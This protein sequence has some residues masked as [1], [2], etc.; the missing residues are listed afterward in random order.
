M[1]SVE[2]RVDVTG[3][4]HAFIILTGPDGIDRGYGP[5]PYRE[6][7][8]QA[9]GHIYDDTNHPYDRTTGKIQISNEQYSRLTDYVNKSIANPPPYDL[10][11]GSQC[12]TWA[13][14]ALT[15]AGIPA[16]ASP[17]LVPDNMFRDLFETIAWNPYTQWINLLARDSFSNA[18][19]WQPRRDPLTLDLD[20]D[21]LETVA[22]S[23]S[24]PI[25]FD[26]DGD[27]LKTSTG[28]VSA[29]DGFLVLDRNGNGL[30]DNGAELFGDATALYTGGLAVDGFA[31][32]AQED[33]NDDGK[34]DAEDGRWRQ[35]M[36]WRDL[37]QDGISQTGELVT[38]DQAGIAS[39]GVA[40]T[41]NS[42]TLANGN[43]I[44]DLGSFV[45]TGGTSGVGQMADINLAED[46]FY[47]QFGDKVAL[48][49]GVAALPELRGSGAVRDLRESASL[50]PDLQA[51]LTQFAQATTGPQQRALLGQLLEAWA[52]TSGLAGTLAERAGGQYAVSFQAIGNETRSG[53]ASADWSGTVDAWERKLHV[54]EAFNGRYFFRLPNEA[55]AGNLAA[56]G[57]TL[58]AATG[59]GSDNGVLQINVA[60]SQ[61]QADLLDQSY[62]ALFQSIYLSLAMQTRLRPVLDE[63]GLVF[64]EAGV[65]LDF[66]AVEQH[67]HE[68][69]KADVVAGLADLIDFNQGVKG[70][71]AT[72]GWQGAAMLAQYMATLPLTAELLAMFAQAGV[73]LVGQDGLYV[74]GSVNDEIMLLDAAGA[75]AYGNGGDDVLVGRAG[76]DRL[77]GD[78]GNDALDGGAGSDTLE[79][80]TGEDMLRGGAGA[81][82]LSGNEGNDRLDGGAGD[83]MLWGGTGD[84]TYLFARGDGVDRISDHDTTAGNMDVVQ[85]T[86]VTSAEVKS[87]ERHGHDLVLRYGDADALTLNFH[88]DYSNPAYK[89]EQIRFSD[90]VRWDEAAIKARVITYGS[91]AGD[92]LSGYADG[93]NQL[94]GLGGND[95]LDGGS[96]N[97]VIDGGGGN[98]TLYGN[99]GDDLL[100][101]GAGDD[102]I[103]GGDGADTIRFGKGYGS[104][105]F[106]SVNSAAFQ[107][108][109]VNLFDIAAT[110][111]DYVRLNNDLEIWVRGATD[112]LTLGDYFSAAG[113]AT[114]VRQLRFADGVTM[115]SAAV[116]NRIVLAGDSGDNSIR[117]FND[118]PNRI[119]GLAGND[120]LDGGSAN[121][122]LA[123][124][125]GND[126]LYGNAGDD[127]LDGG[128]GDDLIYGGDGADTLRFGKGYGAD[129][130]RSTNSAAFQVDTVDL[131]D[132]A[133]TE[134]DYV[135]L[136]NDLEIG[137]RGANDRLTLGDYF[138][139]AGSATT[140]RQLRFAD[141]VTMDSAA[142]RSLVVLAGDSGANI[143]S[144][145]SDGPN[146]IHGLGGNDSLRGGSGND[147]LV[148][149]DGDDTLS[150]GAGNALLIGGTGDD[151]IATG[152]GY[153]IIAFNKG[154]G[155]DTVVAGAGKDNTLSLGGGIS[156]IDLLF[157]R[158]ANDLVLATGE[159]EKIT[160]RDWY[161][162]AGNKSVANLQI[163]AEGGSGD[164]AGTTGPRVAQFDFNGLASRFDEARTTDPAISRWALTSSMMAFHLGSSDTAAIGGELAYQYGS[165]ASVAGL[166]AS[167]GQS[168]LGSAQF[169]MG[170]Q[171]LS[172]GAAL[173][174]AALRPI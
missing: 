79:G 120:S 66:T 45:R 55:G 162:G 96:G 61:I 165:Q 98:D 112:K 109:T 110:E 94:Y 169:G 127:L 64:N 43:Q 143:I 68:A 42:Q 54:L 139:A 8:P 12:A 70:M 48:A 25:L 141:G 34:V 132:I 89:V 155:R 118:G 81:D 115:D 166:S 65:S 11:F 50:S 7:A 145:F 137:V 136:N 56:Q 17:N 60:P 113:G 123:G 121:D 75:S 52:D 163:V 2:L 31:A 161:A 142:V 146:R 138:S 32:L 86:D 40:K 10:Y 106:R 167:L 153:D 159:S 124:G 23:S 27:G 59:N 156:A 69:V 1:L 78:T 46:T 9:D 22:T 152:S 140:V 72:Q 135:R 80:G 71:A 116:R 76:D 24:K 150:G 105:A 84:D 51:L 157:S 122:V 103:Y 125:D 108:D 19:N 5:A 174:D 18:Q 44:A 87:L 170:S 129:A 62:D 100:D 107:V 97:D 88:F 147:V 15:E 73:R 154:D 6:A 30:I 134:V 114:T 133:A 130:F 99:A 102:L 144:G 63:V 38:M 117:G 119:H 148:G 33:S 111:V 39:L 168:Q 41:A 83:D 14:K 21:G 101:G 172:P 3:M 160:F 158:S 36:V 35:L 151:F 77:S 67:F 57:L 104:D 28:W 26:H 131:F 13:V 49:D 47:R 20:N 4:P 171:A 74:S 85:F 173:Q 16:L 93:P 92:S 164:S 82:R 53:S 128:A 37:N 149:G 58:A 126:T 91:M 95:S 90:G 29:D